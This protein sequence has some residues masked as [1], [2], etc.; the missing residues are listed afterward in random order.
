MILKRQLKLEVRDQGRLQ[1][2]VMIAIR[3]NPKKLLSPRK[4]AVGRAKATTPVRD[5]DKEEAAMSSLRNV[6]SCA[7]VRGKANWHSPG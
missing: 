5:K 3:E 4:E 6:K 1:V 7:M 2:R